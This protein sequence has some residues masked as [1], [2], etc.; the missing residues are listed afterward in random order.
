MAGIP[1]NAVTEIYIEKLNRNLIIAALSGG[2]KL[3][4][5][6][7]TTQQLSLQLHMTFQSLPDSE[8]S[9][10]D[11][12]KGVSATD[13]DLCPYCGFSEGVPLVSESPKK[14]EKKLEADMTDTSTEKPKKG[15][16]KKE[17][18]GALVATPVAANDLKPSGVIHTQRELDAAVAEVET[19]KGSAATGYWALG[20]AIERIHVQQLWKLRQE[21]DEKGKTKLRWKTWEAFCHSELKMT[22]KTANRAMDVATRYTEEQIRLW[23]ATKLELLLQAPPEERER[24]MKE[25]VE[26]GAGKREIEKEVRKA[27]SKAGFTRPSRGTHGGKTDATQT[28]SVGSKN[29]VVAE[30]IGTQTIKAYKRPASL[31]NVDWKEQVRAKKLADEPIGVWRMLNDVVAYISVTTSAAGELQFKIAVQREESE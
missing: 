23:G 2:G 5:P 16:K 24:I 9:R 20:R 1:V 3:V 29:I 26:K 11:N 18:N 28:K 31:K 4:D 10:C 6:N 17:A 30:I 25:Q 7:D 19:L 13:L 14:G 12:C 27:K 21:T 22:P 8:K 15:K